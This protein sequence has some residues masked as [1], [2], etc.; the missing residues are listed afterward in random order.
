MRIG[1]YTLGVIGYLYI[2]GIPNML[3]IMQLTTKLI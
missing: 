2:T 1:G 3:I